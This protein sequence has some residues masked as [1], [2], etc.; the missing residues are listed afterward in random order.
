MVM[1]T[2]LNSIYCKKLLFIFYKQIHPKHYHKRKQETFF[3][4]YG[5]VKVSLTKVSKTKTKVV[6][7]CAKRVNK[8]RSI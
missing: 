5:K 2:I 7:T 1:V 3:I 4:L 6:R 8:L